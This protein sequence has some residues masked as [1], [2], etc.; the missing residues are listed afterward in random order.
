MQPYI[1]AMNIWKFF[2]VS[3]TKISKILRL[4]VYP[5]RDQ[6]KSVLISLQNASLVED[7]NMFVKAKPF[8]LFCFLFLLLSLLSIGSSFCF[9]GGFGR[10]I[11][12]RFTFSLL[13]WGNGLQKL[14]KRN[15]VL[16]RTLSDDARR[17]KT[18]KPRHR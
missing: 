2:K 9:W 10:F 6:K 17:N 12:L 16:P 3:I 7:M 13:G 1:E 5:N 14:G 8:V 4:Y 15:V 18:N 11:S